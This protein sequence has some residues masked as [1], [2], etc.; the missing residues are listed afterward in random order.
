MNHL[1]VTLLWIIKVLCACAL[2]PNVTAQ[3]PDSIQTV[4]KHTKVLDV[5]NHTPKWP[6]FVWPIH[7]ALEEVDHA[8]TLQALTQLKQRGIAYSVRWNPHDREKSIQEALRIGKMQ[9]ALGMV[10][11]VD[12]TQCL[13][14]L[15]D[16]SVKTAHLDQNG[17]PF[18]DTSFSPKLGCPFALEH[19]IPVIKERIEFFIQAYQ[20][21]GITPEVIVAD[22]EIDGP[23]EW[24]AAW[25]NSHRCQ[26]CRD[27]LPNT[28]DFRGFQTVLRQLRSQFQQSMFTGPIKHAFPGVHVGNYAVNPHDGHR[29][30]FDYFETLPEQ[31]PVV[32][33][34]GATYRE[35]AE[36]FEAS[37]YTL[38]MP[39]VYTWHRLFDELPFN[40]TDY[41]WF[42]N[43]LKVASN[44][45]S[46]TRSTL[47]SIPFVHWHVTAPPSEP[48]ASVAPMSAE[49][50]QDLLWHMLLRG[51]DSLFLWCQADELA[52]EVALCHE[53]YR[54]ASRFSDF[55]EN[56]QPIE[57]A[58]DPWPGDTISG[59]RLESQVLV[60]RN[61]F[62]SVSEERVIHLDESHQVRVP[63]DHQFG[64]L[65]VEPTPES[66]SWLET[67]F[68]FGF[69]E[70]PKNSSKLE[71]MAQ[72][73]I[74]LVRCQDMEDLDR[75]SKLGMK[76]W[77]S[78]AVQD[79][80]SESL[81]QR[82]SY[83]WH[84]PGLAVWE[85]P[86]E[87]IWTFTAYS[88]LKDKAGF[89]REDWENQIP[90]ATDYAYSVGN[91]LIPRMHHA[92]A[93][94][95]RNDPLKRP[96]WINEAVD[97]DAYFSREMIESV[98]IVGS[99]YY[100]V[101][102]SGTDIQSTS[103]LVSRWNSIGMGRPVWAV[104]QG[105]SWHAIRED[106]DRLYPTFKQSRF[107][108]Y[109]GIVQGVRGCLYW[110][111]ETIDDEEFRQSLFALSSEIQALGPVLS[112]GKD[113]ELDVKVIT[114]LFEVKGS[115]AAIRC[116]QREE[117]V[118]LIVINKDNHRHL[119]V[120]ITGLHHWD[121]KRFHLLYGSEMHR[122]RQGRFITRLQAH[123][124]KV[125]STHPQRARGRSSGRD[126]GNGEIP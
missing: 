71:E 28:I 66:R 73:G 33:E 118:L 76:G 102:A 85:G 60:K 93:W 103:R 38:S 123:E 21:E 79:G 13:Y 126:Y 68:P 42:Y 105:F 78:L 56:G 83:L 117:E 115:G 121:G 46:H 62:G 36:E 82:A 80:L 22:W 96:F 37:G 81:M 34:F 107:M 110:G 25:E 100:A 23:I 61:H 24:N 58:V 7:G 84:H 119:G 51:H 32:H 65:D 98:D 88:F 64:I 104:L 90:K 97:S 124:V 47:P 31:A 74:N 122:P 94:I 14:A 91:D 112:Q 77:I 89:T 8:M 16:G 75:V 41:R 92:I 9:K 1:K 114:D 50:Y 116:L 48:K 40:Q 106:R 10:V 39:V 49:V 72:A 4:L 5:T 11:S 70:L 52:E 26:R 113:I 57:Q 19:R 99:D 30:W 95:K 120:E 108:A 67:N 3:I 111:T 15:F 45:S 53:V 44:A 35:W 18:W 69:Y 55:L 125:F 109:D 101:R 20:V 12:A 27:S 54:E 2:A 43:M 17:N 63:Q 59:L 87:I 86:D 29:Y 6:L